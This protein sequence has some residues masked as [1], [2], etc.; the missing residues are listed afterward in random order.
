MTQ[1][2]YSEADLMA[3]H[4]YAVPQV[5][6]GRRMH[7]GFLADGR[8]QPPRSLVRE[9]AIEAWAEALR[10]RGGELM[11]ADASLLGGPRTPNVAQ[12]VV[13]L[14][15]GLGQT[16]WNTLTI[17]GKIEARGRLLADAAFPDLQPHIVEDISQMGIGHLNTGLLKAHGLDEG[18][19]PDEGIGGHDEMWF[20]ARDLAFGPSAYPD[21]DPPENIARPEAGRRWMP[22]LAPEIEGLLSLLMNLLIIEFRAEI[23]FASTETLLRMPGLFADRSSEAEQAAQIVD[24]IRADEAIHVTS[25]RLYLGELQSVRFHT[26]DAGVAL[27]ADLI[28]RFWSGL[29]QWATVDQPALVAEQQHRLLCERISAHPDADRVLAE[30][31]AAGEVAGPV[32][33]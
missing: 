4:V 18:G 19:I 10:A 2:V 31:L 28:E 32:R 17:T 22:E 16:F 1:L 9:P 21:V 3:E 12:S 30:F 13:L 29:V 11:D 24:R 26:I 23:G 33:S 5:V 14:R 27:G 25:L 20:A 6:A 7:G 8:Y 15:N